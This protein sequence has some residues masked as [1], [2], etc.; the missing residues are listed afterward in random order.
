MSYE[1]NHL[2]ESLNRCIAETNS[3]GVSGGLSTQV[4]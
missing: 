3:V 4:S 2:R 1:I